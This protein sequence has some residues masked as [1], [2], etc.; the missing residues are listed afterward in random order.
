MVIGRNSE[1]VEGCYR[2]NNIFANKLVNKRLAKKYKSP[3]FRD[4]SISAT[5]L[6]NRMD[7]SQTEPNP[8]PSFI[9]A[10]E[11]LQVIIAP[12]SHDDVGNLPKVV[13]NHDVIE[14]LPEFVAFSGL[15][16]RR[17]HPDASVR[18]G[19]LPFVP[20]LSMAHP[21]WR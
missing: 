13:G 15:I 3:N 19:V 18:P 1:E 17:W 2:E 5:L 11:F 4:R 12:N 20:G 7:W 10:P 21:K 16:P 8:A 14:N 9:P 6:G